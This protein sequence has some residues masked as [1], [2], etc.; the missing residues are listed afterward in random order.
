MLIKIRS[1]EGGDSAENELRS[2]ADW[3]ETDRAV[4]RFL[5]AELAS[6][7][8][9]LPGQQGDFIDILSLAL[10]SGFSVASL[11]TAIASWRATRVQPPSLVIERS[12]GTRVEVRG[13][14][15]AE[16]EELVR[17]LLDEEQQTDSSS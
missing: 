6:D 4:A 11:A 16:V 8:T 3:L 2:L 9:R 17:R 12:N 5:R 15:T 1:F 7:A 14:T 10:S 13:S